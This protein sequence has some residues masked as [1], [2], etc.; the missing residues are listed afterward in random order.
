VKNRVAAGQLKESLSIKTLAL[1]SKN[2]FATVCDFSA[3][4]ISH[5][6]KSEASTFFF[7]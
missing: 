5:A 2:S 1:G 3:F 6:T 4:S 7:W